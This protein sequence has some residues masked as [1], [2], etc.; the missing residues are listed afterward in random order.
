MNL[1]VNANALRAPLADGIVQA[2]VTSPPYW[3]LRDYGTDGQLGLE[4][5][6]DC[7]GW[8]TGAPCGEC[9]VCHMVAVF[10]EVKRVLREDGVLFL[11]L[12]D[13]Y[14]GSGKGP[15]GVTSQL[16]N[17]VEQQALNTRSDA[18][19]LKP[20]DLVGIPWRVA[21]ALQADGWWLRSDVIW[22]K[23]NPMPESV[24]DRPTKS[25]EYVFVLTKSARYYWDADAVREEYAPASLPRALRGLSDD[26][27]WS[28]GAPGSTAHTMSQGRPNQRKQ[29]ESE[30][31]GGGSGFSGHS[32]YI[33]ANG[34]LL[35]NPNGRNL[36]T[37]WDIATQPYSGAHYATYPEA[38]VERCL[39]AATSERGCCPVCR[40]PWERVVE[41]E[42]VTNGNG[43]NKIS[44]ADWKDGWEGVPRGTLNVTT[45]GW[46]PTC[47]HEA[48]PVPCTVFD[49]FAGS[50]TTLLVAKRM[51]LH[52]VG[53]DLSYKYLRENAWERV[54]MAQPVLI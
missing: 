25:H 33:D 3:S 23:P 21:L 18:V 37:V 29:W 34:R 47:A 7:L 1:L 17:V 22:S 12:G 48:Q 24:T 49:P 6:H 42:V 32:G 30:H 38:L 46:R 8:A 36:R 27:K 35:V 2:V 50:G 39:K 5:L 16:G 4:P 10:R 19:G 53:L 54:G 43:R 13:S 26:N 9:Y 28:H 14:N 52:G 20:K 45:T 51:G 44:D 40:K 15:A 31:G 11:N 41:K